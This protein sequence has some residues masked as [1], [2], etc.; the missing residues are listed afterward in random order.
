[1]PTN[2]QIWWF[3]IIFPLKMVRSWEFLNIQT[4]YMYIYIP[5]LGSI[6]IVYI[7][8]IYI[9]IV[10][11]YIVYIVYKYIYIYIH[12]IYIVYIVCIVQRWSNFFHSA[13]MVHVQWRRL[14]NEGSPL[15]LRSKRLLDAYRCIPMITT[16][17][18]SQTKVG[19]IPYISPLYAHDL[20]RK[21]TSSEVRLR[22]FRHRHSH[23][24][25]SNTSSMRS[26]ARNQGSRESFLAPKRGPKGSGLGFWGTTFIGNS[27]GYQHI[28]I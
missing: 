11:I 5:I 21:S 20:Y 14:L 22:E 27:W 19:D 7:V 9:Y 6:Y 13:T 26:L 18:Q 24:P 28:S 8:Y 1:M 25:P 17:K 2:P 10:Y 16:P 23:A 3:I 12:S 15:A 4:Q